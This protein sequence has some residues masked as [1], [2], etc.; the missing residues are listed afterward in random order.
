MGYPVSAFHFG[1]QWR[2]FSDR[3]LLPPS[4]T[5]HQDLYEEIV[6]ETMD[7]IAG[8]IAC[9]VD[10]TSITHK[11]ESPWSKHSFPLKEKTQIE[12][13]LR[14]DQLNFWIQRMHELLVTHANFWTHILWP[15]PVS[16]FVP[17]LEILD[18]SYDSV[19]MT[20]NCM[21]RLPRLP[22]KCALACPSTCHLMI[23]ITIY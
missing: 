22:V 18:S 12:I 10:S 7:C 17:K 9:V 3:V 4:G 5:R 20:H 15:C 14:T 11:I 1:G 13:S 19:R 16:P 23:I 8:F 6:S 21:I 2:P